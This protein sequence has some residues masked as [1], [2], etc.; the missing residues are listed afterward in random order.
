MLS[1][2]RR[3]NRYNRRQNLKMV[4]GK[5]GCNDGGRPMDENFNSQ[6]SRV[7]LEKTWEVY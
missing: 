2:I 7:G 4:A 3:F 1:N 5:V 6:H